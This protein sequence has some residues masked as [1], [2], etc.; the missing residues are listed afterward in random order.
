[1]ARQSA[2]MQEQNEQISLMRLQMDQMADTLRKIKLR[3]IFHEVQRYLLNS[4]SQQQQ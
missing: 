2:F 4:Q 3:R 1:M